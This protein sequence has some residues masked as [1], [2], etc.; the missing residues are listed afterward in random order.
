MMFMIGQGERIV[1]IGPPEPQH[2]PRCDE[3]TDFQPQLKY[4]Y[5]RFDLLFGFFYDKQ[6]QLACPKCNHGWLL[7]K[8]IM[9]KRLGKLP[10]PFFL[11]YGF[12]ILLDLFATLGAAYAVMRAAS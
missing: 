8:R 11:R 1:A 9:E 10:I 3:I 7:D 5:G 12:L 4:K 6:Y 2:C